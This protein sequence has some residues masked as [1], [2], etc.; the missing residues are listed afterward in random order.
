LVGIP[1]NRKSNI[2]REKT[3]PIHS[4]HT[5]SNIFTGFSFI[6]N[7]AIDL[8]L[9]RDASPYLYSFIYALSVI[10]LFLFMP[11]SIIEMHFS[12]VSSVFAQELVETTTVPN[13]LTP[14]LSPVQEQQ[15]EQQQQEQ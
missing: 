10:I 14:D 5:S 15:K 3:V 7:V 8:I 13:T 12:P 4:F 11:V 6:F 9:M 2:T 1:V